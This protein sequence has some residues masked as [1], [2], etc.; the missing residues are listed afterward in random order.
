MS[1]LI[2]RKITHCFDIMM[3]SGHNFDKNNTLANTAA[4]TII[5]AVLS[6]S[7]CTDTDS[8]PAARTSFLIKEGP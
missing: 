1:N 2:E 5:S 3:K 6:D 8:F 4:E 7:L